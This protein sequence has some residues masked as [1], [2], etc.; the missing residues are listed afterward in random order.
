MSDSTTKDASVS[1]ELQKMEQA[2]EAETGETNSVDSS[3]TQ[4]QEAPDQGKAIQELAEKK[5]FKSADDFAKFLTNLEKQNTRLA[6][7]MSGLKGE[8]R[9]VATPQPK[10]DDNLPPEQKQALDM[11]RGLIREEISGSLEPL[12]SDF[13]TRRA[14][15]SINKVKQ[16]Y[17]VSDLD[18]QEALAIMEQNPKLA[19]EDAVKI[20]TYEQRTEQASIQQGRTAKAQQKSRAFVESAKS[21]KSTGDTDYSKLSLEELEKIIPAHGEFIDHKGVL[22][23]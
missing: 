3:D 20:A 10:A 2:V 18:V 12:R 15:E 19:L 8:I 17:G 1:D 7:E 11:L 5:G 23:K 16:T 14:Q 9:K 4:D 6:Q 13:E 22:R 21:S